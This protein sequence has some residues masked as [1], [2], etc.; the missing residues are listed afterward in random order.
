MPKLTKW[1]IK[2]LDR[3]NKLDNYLLWYELFDNNP[4]EQ[5]DSRECWYFYEI[6]KEL[7][8]RLQGDGF[9]GDDI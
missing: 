2:L 7:Y 5:S 9:F 6:K 8:N 4:T 3:I 1:Q